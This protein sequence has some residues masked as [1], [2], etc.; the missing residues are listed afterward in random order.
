VADYELRRGI[1]A[2]N[3]QVTGER[4]QVAII[5]SGPAGLTCAADLAR[6]GYGV[7][8][9]EALPV[10]GGMMA[11]GIPSY[12]LPREIL[13]VEIAAIEALGVEIKLNTPVGMDV[14]LSDLTGEFATVFV[15]T[16][17]QKT[18]N[19]GIPG[20]EEV[21]H[22][23]IDWMPL[24]RGVALDGGEKPGDTVVVVGG[25]NTAVDSA[26][27][28]RRLG[29]AEVHILYRRSR[30]E[31]PAF[32]EEV[33]D[34]EAEGINV[35]FLAAPKRLLAE[36]GR[37]KGIECS[38]M[39]L[40][41]KDKTGR[42][43][44]VPLEGSE[45]VIPCDTV[46][47]AIG[48]K[49]DSSFLSPEERLEI[50]DRGLLVVDPHTLATNREGVFAGGD[51][52]TGPS[53]VVEAI[54]AGH[55]GARSIVRYLSGLPP[56]HSIDESHP[57][58]EE[59]SIATEPPPNATRIHGSHL[60][61]KDRSGSFDEIEQGLTEAQAIVEAER[62]LRCGPCLECTHCVG[63]CDTRQVIMES[64]EGDET[65]PLMEPGILVRVP[66]DFHGRVRARGIV[67]VAYQTRP[68]RMSV[69][70]AHVDEKRCVGCGLCEE[71]CGYRAVRVLYL[72]N[73]V[74][75][76]RVDD[77]MCRGCGTCI[78]YCP[79]GA[80]DQYHFAT[81]RL[82]RFIQTGLH[83]YGD[84]PPIAVF[85]CLWNG[86]FETGPSMLQTPIV[87]VMCISRVAAGDVIRAF[88]AGAAG[89][90]MVGCAED[91]CHYGFGSH[92]AAHNVT[93]ASDVLSLL[94]IEPT[95]LRVEKRPKQGAPSLQDVVDD[96]IA[97]IEELGPIP[98]ELTIEK[99]PL[100][101]H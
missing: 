88:G 47:P 99:C 17:A 64:S 61:A 28:T 29:A 42:P 39:G 58:L 41:E 49:L 96:F 30:Q 53:S 69:F 73:G 1:I 20:E 78:P 31:M 62:C 79:S 97:D 81:Q 21:Q 57:G 74:F 76:A 82:E 89:V 6:Q 93:R 10:P 60:G 68:Y 90:L 45:F 5:G 80:L 19:L 63:V 38:R 9:F 91:D 11:V 8:V 59:L 27:V 70:T 46:I 77:D 14:T 43:R 44:P 24:L 2:K 48:Q 52:A 50:S 67:P 71:V 92:A 23:L 75:T 66:S 56:E 37:L 16:G 100:S 85:A 51:A 72:G 40:G 101:E 13:H 12:R 33:S 95:R 83:P 18:S 65:Q 35:Q 55:R 94:G 4:D 34:A 98:M 86:P 7:T 3:D 36:G 15:A 87:N 84:R 25:G 26:R 22:G 54:A 32:G